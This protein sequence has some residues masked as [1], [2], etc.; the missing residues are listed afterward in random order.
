MSEENQLLKPIKKVRVSDTVVDQIMSLIESGS[1]KVG[2]QLPTERELVSQWQVARASVREALRILEFSGVIEV[3]PGIGAFIIGDT[4]NLEGEE[5]VRRWF[6]DHASKV[7]GMLEVREALESRAARL[8]A[9]RATPEQIDDI[10]AVLDEAENCI[11]A[12]DVDQLVYLDRKFHRCVAQASQN[13]LF[14]E[15]IDIVA[16]AMMSPR[17]SI[18]RLPGRARESWDDHR[19]ILN[20]VRNG[21]PD[22][23]ERTIVSHMNRVNDAITTLSQTDAQSN[24]DG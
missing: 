7:I 18:L 11:A 15:L 14:S 22:E 6:Q 10:V 24:G 19:A 17:R 23:A 5:S 16:D 8:A 3:R 1:L 2:D 21:D 13:Q 9:K 20:A 4:S 12:G